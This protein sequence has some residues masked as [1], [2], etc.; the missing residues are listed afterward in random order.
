MFIDSANDPGTKEMSSPV[1]STMMTGGSG[2]FGNLFDLRKHPSSPGVMVESLDF[3]T[4]VTNKITVEVWTREGSALGAAYPDAS[5]EMI[6]KVTLS[7]AGNGSFTSIPASQFKP[8][9]ISELV[10]TRGFLVILTSADLRYTPHEKGE[11]PPADEEYG[12]I[13]HDAHLAITSGDG[14]KIYP[15]RSR[16]R[17]ATTKFRAWNGAVH[18]KV[19]E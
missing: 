4:D 15:Y 1:L 10:P 14:V 17:G 13:S 11:Y 9:E 12:I 6:A 19:I 7:G 8:V 5:W 3:Y 16:K 18:Y 2:S